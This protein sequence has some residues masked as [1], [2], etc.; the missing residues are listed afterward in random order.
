M[1][2]E[3]NNMDNYEAEEKNIEEHKYIGPHA[4]LEC[5]LQLLFLG[6]QHPASDAHRP[7]VLSAGMPRYVFYV[8][9]ED[10]RKEDNEAVEKD[11]P[12]FTD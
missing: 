1:E 10:E 9:E 11:Q 7:R 4:C 6:P 8:E 5:V 3:K 12:I 2:G